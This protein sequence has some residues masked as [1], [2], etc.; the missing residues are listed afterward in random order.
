MDFRNS[1]D[2]LRIVTSDSRCVATAIEP[3]FEEVCSSSLSEQLLFREVR[4][5]FAGEFRMIPTRVHG[6]IDYVVGLLLIAAPF[7]FGFAN[8]SAAQWVPMLLGA[9]TIIYSLLTDYE[10]SFIG[11]IPMPVHLGLDMGS[12]A[13]LAASPWIFG[14]SG[15][16]WWPHVLVG[17]MEVVIPMLTSR[18][19]QR[20]DHR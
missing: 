18:H 1:K 3:R 13:L 15:V 9:S 2:L 11:L 14:F 10:L 16:I 5:R 17:A 12:G 19:P 20:V 8:G 4:S 7:L 6:V